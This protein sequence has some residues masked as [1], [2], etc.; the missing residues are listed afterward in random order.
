[1]VFGSSPSLFDSMEMPGGLGR[2]V[3]LQWEDVGLLGNQGVCG[4]A[5]LLLEVFV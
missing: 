4:T 2:L 1:M 3:G 5:G